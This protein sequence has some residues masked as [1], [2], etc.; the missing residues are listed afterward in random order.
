MSWA[1]YILQV[2]I[3]LIVFYG[4]YKFLLDK[5]TYFVLNRL[6][7]VS[8]GLLS[9]A[10]PFLRFEW[11]IRQPLAQPVYASVGEMNDYISVA[12]VQDNMSKITLANVLAFIYLAGVV[13]FVLRFIVQLIFVKILL[14]RRDK[15]FAFSFF[16]KKVIDVTLP[17]FRTI[18]SHEDIHIRQLHS[19]DVVFFELL[20]IIN[21]FNPIIYFYKH[22][23]KNIHEFLADEQA[24]RFQGDKEQYALLLL[25]S[26]FG[27]TPSNLTNSFF[28]KSLIK[29]RIYMLHKQR[30]K[31]TAVLKY[32]LFLPLFAITLVMSSATIRKNERILAIAE[33]IPLSEPLQMIK[34]TATSIT[35]GNISAVS[36]TSFTNTIST[37]K[38]A[39]HELG[40]HQAPDWSGLMNHL[41]KSIKYPAAATL[42]QTQGSTIIKFSVENGEP[43][44]V[45]V[46][47][48]SLGE[49]TDAEV[50]S[51]IL[52]YTHFKDIPDG[53][54][55]IKTVFSIAGV[56]AE[57]K[58]TDLKQPQGYNYIGEVVIRS[59]LPA[60][61]N[62]KNDPTDLKVYDFVSLE[63]QPTFPGG[64]G[65]FYAYLKENLRYPAEAK[66]NKVEGHVFLSFVV[67]KD[68]SLM[69]I[70][71]DRKL[72]GGTDEE[73][74]RIL[75]ESP[76]WLPGTQGGNAVR[77]KYNIPIS[78]KLTPAISATGSFTATPTSNTSGSSEFIASPTQEEKIHDFVSLDKQPTFPGGMAQFYQ[79]LK[80]TVR[81]PK[82]AQEENIQGKVFLS[83]VVEKNGE[84]TNIKVDRKLGGGTDEEAIR[85]MKLSPHWI[86]GVLDKKPVRVKYN[87]PISFTLSQ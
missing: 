31:K 50:M 73:A 17:E 45:S 37:S 85:V 81:Y 29:K 51:R 63:S 66:A 15:G 41:K 6:Y 42:N 65:K 13:F 82:E 20:G 4:F 25:S 75:R 43:K 12:I 70:K 30:S 80:R 78:F 55:S 53:K 26:A 18:N 79:F 28:N 19:I 56:T 1:H 87:I 54:Y 64:M 35:G 10:L 69:D 62:A 59:Y 11:F 44:E 58:P 72:G 5:E 46:S 76:K 21:W 7:L 52:T 27:V 49:G 36:P 47:G 67:E 34:E 32:G 86:P 68:G 23:I 22:S 40:Q 39:A 24:A 60:Q 57:Q 16:G 61:T 3:Y 9:I 8:A 2:N 84:L 71:V 33:K 38:L 74:V 48:P 14:K 77:V 83:F